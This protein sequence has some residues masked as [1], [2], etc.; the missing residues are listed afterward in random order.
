MYDDSE[1]I[2]LFISTI[3]IIIQNLIIHTPNDSALVKPVIRMNDFCHKL[4]IHEAYIENQLG[5]RC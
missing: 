2:N 3:S 5:C 4:L 1:I